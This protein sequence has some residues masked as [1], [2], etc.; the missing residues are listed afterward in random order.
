MP[1]ERV[2]KVVLVNHCW[3]QFKTFKIEKFH[4]EIIDD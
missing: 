1:A 2:S 3:L 4:I